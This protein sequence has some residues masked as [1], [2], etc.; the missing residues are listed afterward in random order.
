MF[1]F[2]TIIATALLSSLIMGCATPPKSYIDPTT[3]KVSYDDLSKKGEPVKLQLSVEFQQNGVPKPNL[4]SSFKD[5]TAR[6]LRATNVILPTDNSTA[7]N[8]K[9][10]V[11]NTFDKGA[12]I[13]KKMGSDLT[14]GLAGSTIKDSYETSVTLSIK[15]KTFTHSN[16]KNAIY[17]TIGNANPPPGVEYFT[18]DVSFNR[19]L[20][21]MLLTALQD[22]QKSGELQTP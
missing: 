18:S 15:G 2:K 1:N 19:V 3:P 10:V 7:G 13:G 22:M 6:I 8:I 21:Q 17:S 4:E 9:V 20:E 12:L 11:N 5:L 14:F 16:I